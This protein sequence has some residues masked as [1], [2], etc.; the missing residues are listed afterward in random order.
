VAN[1]TAIALRRRSARHVG[2]PPHRGWQPQEYRPVFPWVGRTRRQPPGQGQASERVS[3]V[4]VGNQS[5]TRQHSN[6]AILAGHH[7]SAGGVTPQVAASTKLGTCLPSV[8]RFRS[9]ELHAD[10]LRDLLL[11]DVRLEPSARRT[12]GS[13]TLRIGVQVVPFPEIECGF[14]KGRDPSGVSRNTRAANA[15]HVYGLA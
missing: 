10:C 5:S 14:R 2:A 4:A 3:R 7:V 1:L 12:S 8:L 6:Q 15:S 11:F 9:R 13:R